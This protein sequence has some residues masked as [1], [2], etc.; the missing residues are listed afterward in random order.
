[1]EAI[2][3]VLWV[4]VCSFRF[5]GA[6]FVLCAGLSFVFVYSRKKVLVLSAAGL[7]RYLYAQN[8]LVVC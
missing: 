3:F 6:F 1:M 8:L 4:I 7:L 5:M 2:G